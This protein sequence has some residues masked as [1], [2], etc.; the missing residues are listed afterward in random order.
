MSRSHSS[1]I[2]TYLATF[3]GFFTRLSANRFFVASLLAAGMVLPAQSA[4]AQV[5]QD[6][7][8]Y[9][10]QAVQ[11]A[12]IT[13]GAF[14]PAQF[15]PGTAYRSESASIFDNPASAALLKKSFLEK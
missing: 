13:T 4:N 3:S 10:H 9:T 5:V 15:M 7:L 11:F 6:P 1:L 8:L 14:Q 12:G 2:S